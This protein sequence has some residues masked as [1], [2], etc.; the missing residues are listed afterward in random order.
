MKNAVLLLVIAL[1]GCATA[2]KTYTEN[3]DE[4]YTIDCSGGA[5]TWGMCYEKAGKLCGPAG[6]TTLRKDGDTGSSFSG[7]Q[8]G[9]YGG[10]VV[11]RSM[12]ISCHKA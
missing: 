12:V 4:G 8:F 7:N 1:S 11:S 6:Y 3:G 5:L 2:T 10:T 9:L